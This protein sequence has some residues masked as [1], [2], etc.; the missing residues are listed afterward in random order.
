MPSSEN[1]I[2]RGSRIA[3][4]LRHDLVGARQITKAKRR[5]K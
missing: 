2:V 1:V 4:V 5:R 3:G